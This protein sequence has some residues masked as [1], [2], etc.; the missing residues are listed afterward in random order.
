MNTPP[1]CPKGAD[2]YTSCSLMFRHEDE[3]ILATVDL[4]AQEAV[5][6]GRD[7]VRLSQIID[8]YTGIITAYMNGRIHALLFDKGKANDAE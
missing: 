5:R 2:P 4:F 1:K 3:F 6:V 8:E 7:E